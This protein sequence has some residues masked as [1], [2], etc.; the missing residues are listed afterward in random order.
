DVVQL[1]PDRVGRLARGV[2]TGRK[3]LDASL[4]RGLA[5]EGIH[6]LDCLRPGMRHGPQRS[7]RRPRFSGPIPPP[8]AFGPGPLRLTV[9][10]KRARV[11]NVIVTKAWR[12]ALR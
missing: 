3:L 7:V 10:A 12:F 1:A 9:A 8:G 4:G 2:G 6:T 11:G 5:Q